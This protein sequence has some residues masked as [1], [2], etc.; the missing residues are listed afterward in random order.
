[1]N[2]TKKYNL[3]LHLEFQELKL[4][5]EYV[6]NNYLSSK[7][8]RNPYS[9][10]RYFISLNKIDTPISYL[11]E[12]IY[13]RTF[14]QLDIHDYSIEPMFGIFLGVNESGANVQF[15]IDPTPSDKEHVRINFLI[16]KPQIG[17]IPVINGEHLDIE[18][19]Q[20]WVNIASA[21]LHGSTPVESNEIRII[22][23]LGALID[24]KEK[25]LYNYL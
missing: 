20:G 22:L 14:K 5:K 2:T 12:Q 16:N 4:L 17:G 6:R 10:G 25:W 18:E 21:W 15:H 24:K 11:A 1:M 7:F 3:P 9:K 19:G 23:S 13:H 8:T